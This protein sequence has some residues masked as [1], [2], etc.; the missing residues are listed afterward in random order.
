MVY[1]FEGCALPDWCRLES[2]GT[3]NYETLEIEED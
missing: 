2:S 3:V 1:Y